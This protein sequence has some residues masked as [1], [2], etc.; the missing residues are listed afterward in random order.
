MFKRYQALVKDNDPG[1]SE[2]LGSALL[3]EWIACRH[4]SRA[5]SP[6][7]IFMHSHAMMQRAG[8]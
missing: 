7:D 5:P 6:D 1:K 2:F 4:L 8:A 3:T